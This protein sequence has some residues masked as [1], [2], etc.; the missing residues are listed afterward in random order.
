[1]KLLNFGQLQWLWLQRFLF[2]EILWL[3]C[4]MYHNSFSSDL[5]S[6]DQESESE[7]S[8]SNDEKRKRKKKKSKK[9]K[10][11]AKHKKSAK[12]KKR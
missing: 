8:S 4:V 1:M 7:D 11:K 2:V 6:P 10:K 5:E 9:K 3:K 12:H